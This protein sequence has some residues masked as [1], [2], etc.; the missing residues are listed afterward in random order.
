MDAHPKPDVRAGSGVVPM[1]KGVQHIRERADDKRKPRRIETEGEPVSSITLEFPP[2]FTQA[3]VFQAT[4]DDFDDE[5][6]KR[7]VLNRR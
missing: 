7:R 2:H 5:P 6:D 1:E 4:V 3:G